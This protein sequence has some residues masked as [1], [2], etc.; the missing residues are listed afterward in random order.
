MKRVFNSDK[1]KRH[2]KKHGYIIVP[3]LLNKEDILLLNALFTK[4]HL[5]NK[6]AFHSSHFS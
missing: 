4:Y 1:H 3:G 6:T 2:F 5:E